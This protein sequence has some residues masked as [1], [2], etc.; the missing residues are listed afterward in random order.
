[1][2]SLLKI[3]GLDANGC[4]LGTV[5]PAS[6]TFQA[7]RDADVR[8]LVSIC[9]YAAGYEY[10]TLSE[11]L[12]GDDSERVLQALRSAPPVSVTERDCPGPRSSTAIMVRTADRVIAWVYY[13]GCQG[14]HVDLGDG[15]ERQVT[16]EVLYMVLSPGWVGPLNPNL[17]LPPVLRVR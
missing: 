14:V 2:A 11:A 10:L 3:N 7:H 1:M 17:P 6:G 8:G 12:S 15:G 9:H 13:R 4:E 5:V 16:E